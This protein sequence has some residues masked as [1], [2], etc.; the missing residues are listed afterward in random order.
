MPITFNASSGQVFNP[1]PYTERIYGQQAE[2]ARREAESKRQFVGGVANVIGQQ[3][4]NYYDQQRQQENAQASL[5]QQT[6]LNE[7][8]AIQKRN[9]ELSQNYEFDPEDQADLA[10]MDREE[11]K[12][13]LDMERR[14]TR[15]E[16]GLQAKLDINRRRALITPRI[17]RVDARGRME[18]NTVTDEV[19]GAKTYVSPDGNTIKPLIPP[20]KSLQSEQ[21]KHANQEIMRQFT[22]T[23]PYKLT[24]Q[25]IAKMVQANFEGRV[26]DFQE[27]D[28]EPNSQLDAKKAEDYRLKQEEARQKAIEK[29]EE[30]RRKQIEGDISEAMLLQIPNGRGG[31]RAPTDEEI[32]AHL[33]KKAQLRNLLSGKRSRQSGPP[34]QMLPGQPGPTIQIPRQT[35]PEFGI[36]SEPAQ[37]FPP[38]QPEAMSQQPM[39]PAPLQ[40][41]SAI[42]ADSLTAKAVQSG[43][44]E[45]AAALQLA[46][47][48]APKLL[49]G[50]ITAEEE[51]LL[52]EANRVLKQNNVKL[53]SSPQG[54]SPAKSRRSVPASFSLRGNE[55]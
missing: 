15:R 35:Q 21:V 45:M 31:T 46:K 34:Q 12:I 5:L 24:P 28:F 19:T 26:Y 27:G 48:L 10:R 42:K 13:D 52:R 40:T 6:Y 1:L 51:A 25:G 43:N 50:E 44:T 41:A 22:P 11:R 4:S 49:T 54:A 8:A 14:V 23:S 32:M 18:A 30:V 2:T 3:V 17:P 47:R 39:Q 29:Q 36:P 55:A 37:S 38:V 7:R 53:Y 16:H 9:A 20:A 33:A